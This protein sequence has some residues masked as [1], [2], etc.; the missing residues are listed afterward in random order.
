[1]TPADAQSIPAHAPAAEGATTLITCHANADFDA[2]AAMRQREHM[3]ALRAR[4]DPWQKA[5]EAGA[6]TVSDLCDLLQPLSL[7]VLL[8]LMADTGDAALQKNISRYIT[9]WRAEK[10]DVGGEDLRA[11][12]L[13][14]GPAY[15]RIL[16]A[17]LRAKR[18][19]LVT[20]PAQQLELARSLVER[21][22]SGAKKAQS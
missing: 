12:G 14:P 20:S 6:A 1:M 10:P 16:H 17:V 5:H 7:G 2:F 22:D 21:A 4:L 8:Y 13:A 19:G 11:M 9:Q 15:G 18:D 3:R